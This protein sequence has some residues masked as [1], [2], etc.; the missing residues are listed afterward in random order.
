[1]KIE[2][3]QT[4]SGGDTWLEVNGVTFGVMA[5]SFQLMDCDGIPFRGI[6]FHGITADDTWVA[7][8]FARILRDIA[9]QK[10]ETKGFSRKDAMEEVFTLNDHVGWF[11]D[12]FYLTEDDIDMNFLR[13]LQHDIIDSEER[14]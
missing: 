2:N 13:D 4:D 7:F 11:M 10:E 3:I 12:Y 6:P 5:D 14:E 1:M 9:E 8:Q